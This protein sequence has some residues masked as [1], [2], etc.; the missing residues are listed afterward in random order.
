MTKRQQQGEPEQST[1]VARRAAEGEIHGPRRQMVPVEDVIPMFDT[2]KFEQMARVAAAMAGSS[3]LPAHIRGNDEMTAR[4]NA[5]L[6][7][8]MAYQ[9]QVPPLQLAQVSYVLHGKMGFEGKFVHALLEKQLGTPFEFEYLNDESAGDAFRIRVTN[10]RPADRKPVSIEGTV[11]MWKTF[12]KDGTT[13]KGNWRIDPR[14]QLRY[15]GVV[16][17][18]RAYS[19]GLVLGLLTDDEL[20][21]LRDDLAERRQRPQ[22][23]IPSAPRAEVQ[24]QAEE[25]RAAPEPTRTIEAT[26][27]ETTKTGDIVAPD[28]EAIV[29]ETGQKASEAGTRAALGELYEEVMNLDGMPHEVEQR[30]TEL[31]DARDKELTARQQAAEKPAQEQA[32]TARQES[33][34][35]ATQKEPPT[36]PTF[37]EMVDEFRERMAKADTPEKVMALY[38]MRPVR[39]VPDAIAQQFT[40]I[41]T[42]RREELTGKPA[43]PE[44]GATEDGEAAAKP[45]LFKVKDALKKADSEEELARLW[46]TMIAPHQ[47]D[48]ED[49]SDIGKTRDDRARQLRKAKQKPKDG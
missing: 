9:F 30:L 33:T 29:K 10:E 17:W 47:W 36:A 40:D 49:M 14:K 45:S 12:E 16:E 26:A 22:I 27:T 1:A 11:G 8:S 20:D 23:T 24:A 34:A 7:V 48:K 4:A 38:D 44:P 3:L 28:W 42:K 15:R 19:P 6:I 18:G 5:F 37:G 21:N 39:G 43:G 2:A 46:K 35:T 32:T 13:V 41:A 25:A 31:F